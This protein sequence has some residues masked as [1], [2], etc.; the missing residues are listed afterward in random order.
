MQGL[1]LSGGHYIYKMMQVLDGGENLLEVVDKL[2]AEAAAQEAALQA[3][4]AAEAVASSRIAQ[5]EEEHLHTEEKYSSIQVFDLKAHLSI[6]G[7]DAQLTLVSMHSIQSM[8]R[9]RVAMCSYSVIMHGIS[10][11]AHCQSHLTR[12]VTLRECMISAP[13][14][15]CEA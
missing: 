7:A 3:Q 10:V 5:L 12:R 6:H 14:N 15:M 13:T 8:C 11:A 1:V 4:I 9:T 2:T